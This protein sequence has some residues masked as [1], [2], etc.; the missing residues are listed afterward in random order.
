[1]RPKT[2]QHRDRQTD[3]HTDHAATATIGRIVF[4]ILFYFLVLRP[5]TKQNSN[6]IPDNRL[7]SV[8]QI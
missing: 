5:K 4:F 6:G 7:R 8:Q 2:K 1:M 3:K